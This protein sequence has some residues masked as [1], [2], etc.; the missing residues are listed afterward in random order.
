VRLGVAFPAVFT[1]PH[2]SVGFLSNHLHLQSHEAGNLFSYLFHYQGFF[3]DFL[4]PDAS[5]IC[6]C[7]GSW[8]RS[9][10]KLK[11]AFVSRLYLY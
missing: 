7:R 4:Y 2:A 11:R 8:S 1:Q 9:E 6:F 5:T 3:Q 10:F